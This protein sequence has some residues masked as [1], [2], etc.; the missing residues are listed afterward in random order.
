LLSGGNTT[1]HCFGPNF[2]LRREVRKS[3]SD[4]SAIVMTC[5]GVIACLFHVPFHG[6]CLMVTCIMTET[7]GDYYFFVVLLQ[8]AMA[9]GTI[10]GKGYQLTVQPVHIDR[11]IRGEWGPFP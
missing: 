8:K 10:G 7:V 6:R 1:T 5:P 9:Y 2:I 11:L 3:R 4:Q